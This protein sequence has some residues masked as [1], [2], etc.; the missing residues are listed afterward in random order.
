MEIEVRF[1]MFFFLLQVNFTFSGPNDYDR[2][3]GR[4]GILGDNN[5]ND[6]R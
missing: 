5:C 1:L 2:D 4:G 3:P 6:G